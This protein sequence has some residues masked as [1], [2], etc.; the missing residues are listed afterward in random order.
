MILPIVIGF[1]VIVGLIYFKIEHK[2]KIV[3][4]IILVSLFLLL[5]FS[6]T[7]VISLQEIDFTS[8]RQVANVLYIY[9][10]WVGDTLTQLWDIGKETA[11]T[12]GH[13]I[14]LNETEIQKNLLNN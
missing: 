12:V 2:G 5:Y 8:P 13:T 14:K 1:L 9:V 10:G 11:S 4:A 3:K 6:L 7:K